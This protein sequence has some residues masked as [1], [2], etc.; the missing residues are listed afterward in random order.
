MVTIMTFALLFVQRLLSITFAIDG[1]V[2]GSYASQY[3]ISGCF[4]Y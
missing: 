1:S 3:T 2:G 4:Y